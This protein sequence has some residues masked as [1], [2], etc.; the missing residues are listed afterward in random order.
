M[1]EKFW[2]WTRDDRIDFYMFGGN[3]GRRL[4]IEQELHEVDHMLTPTDLSILA[5][6]LADDEAD[7]LFTTDR[8]LLVNIPVGEYLSE[9]WQGK[10]ITSL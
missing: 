8:A 3:P 9:N 1:M 4:N 10:A 7:L 5:C 6:F 2:S